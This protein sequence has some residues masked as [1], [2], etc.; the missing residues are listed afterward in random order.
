V[1][2][3]TKDCPKCDKDKP[4][5]QF[6]KNASIK[7]GFQRECALCWNAYCKERWKNDSKDPARLRTRS[8]V[9]LRTKYGIT[10]EQYDQMLQAQ[11]G[12]CK[13][14]GC[15]PELGAVKVGRLGPFMI[16][17]HERSCCP[18]TKTCGKCIRGLVCDYC[19]RALGYVD[20]VGIGRIIAHVAR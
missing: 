2:E 10:V 6:Q 14:C 4:L 11:G 13:V 7:D 16:V 15:S 3:A 18:G 17:D 9:H 8:N 20:R 1:E 19:N 12:G 5:A